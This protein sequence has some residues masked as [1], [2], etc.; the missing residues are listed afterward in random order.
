MSHNTAWCFLYQPNSYYHC[1]INSIWHKPYTLVPLYQVKICHFVQLFILYISQGCIRVLK[2]QN[3]IVECTIKNNVQ[4][5]LLCINYVLRSLWKYFK[6]SKSQRFS[7]ICS[8]WMMHQII[9]NFNSGGCKMALHNAVPSIQRYHGV[10]WPRGA[11]FLFVNWS[12]CFV[13]I[14]VVF[15]VLWNLHDVFS[16][17]RP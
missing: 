14:V 2:M 13:F 12:I 7:T 15:C 6:P 5:L 1:R 17:A 8:L 16:D 3:F 9:I 10:S 4:K 11:S